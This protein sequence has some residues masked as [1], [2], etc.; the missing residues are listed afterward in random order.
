MN[1]VKMT[2]EHDGVGIKF[3]DESYKLRTNSRQC[4]YGIQRQYRLRC[5]CA[6]L[7]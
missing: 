5:N 2:V 3:L 7:S 1:K 4:S 6:M